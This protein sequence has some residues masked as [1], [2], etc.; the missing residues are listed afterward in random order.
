MRVTVISVVLRDLDHVLW[1]GEVERE[2]E[3]EES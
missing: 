3:D 1:R 2:G